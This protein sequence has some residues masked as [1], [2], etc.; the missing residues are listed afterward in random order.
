MGLWIVVIQLLESMTCWFIKDIRNFS[1]KITA[2]TW[3]KKIKDENEFLVK[4]EG[5]KIY[6][7]NIF[8]KNWFLSIK[9]FLLLSPMNES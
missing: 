6:L 8:K 7:I 5:W 4:D 2:K 3:R 1:L 9:F